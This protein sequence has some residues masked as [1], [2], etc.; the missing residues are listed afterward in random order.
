M[1][2][3]AVIGIILI[4][5][6]AANGTLVGEDE[7][8]INEAAKTPISILGI[9]SAVVALV[10]FV[11]NLVGLIIARKDDSGFRIALL[12]TVLG[13]IASAVSAIWSTN[14][15][16]VKWMDTLTTIFSMFASYYVLTGI[17]NLA[18]QIPDAATKALALK[19]RTLVEGSFC[20]TVIFKL[21]ISIFK[22]QDGSTL[23][24]IL[25]IVALLLELVS[26]ILYLRA[27]SK[28]K[29]MLAK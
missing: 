24:T 6:I 27:L 26:Y 2:L 15:G 9:V 21:I 20:A 1:L 14:A 22:I 13:I 17:A 23:Y 19:S 29:K 16:L 3:A 8:V 18:D 5:V 10:A 7:I 28:G 25:S 12:V 4:F 11:L